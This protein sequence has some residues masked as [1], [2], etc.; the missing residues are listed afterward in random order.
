VVTLEQNT[1]FSRLN[2]DEL[3]ALRQIAQERTL[4]PAEEIFKEGDAGDG[5]YVVKEGL[6]E[7]AVRAGLTGRHVFTWIQ[8]GDIFG[9][10]AVIEDKPRSAGA[11]A[12][13]ASAVYFIPRAG[14]LSLMERSPTLTLALLR[15]ISH[16]LREFNHHYMREVLQAERLAVVGRFARSIVHDLKNPLN[17][18]G[19]T[20]EMAGMGQG[21]P[22]LQEK[23]M[24]DIRLQVDRIND[25]VG[26]ILD[27]TQGVAPALV[28]PPV[29]YAQFVQQVME[30][31]RSE[32]SMRTVSVELENSPPSVPVLLNPKRL[33]RVFFNLV[34]NATDA[35]G[36]GGKISWRFRATSTEVITEVED[37]GPGIAPEIAGH[38]F[39][40]FATYGKANGTGLG[41]SICKKILEDHGGWITTRPEPGHGAIF[42]FGLPRVGA[43]SVQ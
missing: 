41:L 12:R 39:E 8:P 29:D 27:F 34:H 4:A 17:I 18:I 7:I 36:G 9:E 31:I 24:A 21:T 19:L 32:I 43:C 25:L 6:V 28:L 16:R 15:E 3:K 30:A 38:L 33:R 11:T 26:E 5:V 40:A 35:M 20:A 22:G 37:T 42:T 23:A 1:L 13:E 14:M 2:P 10:M